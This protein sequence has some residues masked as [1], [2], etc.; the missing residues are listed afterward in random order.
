M[1]EKDISVRYCPQCGTSVEISGNFCQRCGANLRTKIN[2]T[3]AG[4]HETR[5]NYTDAPRFMP[6]SKG[7]SHENSF[8]GHPATFFLLYIIALLPTY[9]LP[10]FGSNSVLAN[11]VSTVAD[12]G[13]TSAF[14]LHIASIYILIAVSWF[15]GT[16]IGRSWLPSLPAIAG[17]F[18][19]VP[20]LNWMPLVPTGFHVATLIMA[21]NRE[22]LE[23]RVI[24]SKK[25]IG[26]AFGF[27]LLVF[28]GFYEPSKVSSDGG[29]QI[30][31]SKNTALE[32]VWAL[33]ETGCA[34]GYGVGYTSGGRFAEGDEFSGIEGKWSIESDY[35]IRKT[36]L[37]Y[38][39]DLSGE[40]TVHKFQRTDRFS[41]LKLTATQLVI[42]DMGRQYRYVRCHE[43]QRIFVDGTVASA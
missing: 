23:S 38:T 28:I 2:T 34:T 37:Q 31:G 3:D 21:V 15:R 9:I 7:K 32:G 25:L 36:T 8:L 41:I 12:F 20:G 4:G 13:L 27:L 24:G 35:L 42:E 19:L 11:S 1:R 29:A 14:W 40:P 43:G 17:M 30:F 18:D 26:S 5:R 10:Y 33:E 6:I 16:L 22:A 39:D